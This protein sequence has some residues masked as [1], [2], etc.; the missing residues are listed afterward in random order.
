MAARWR[1]PSFLTCGENSDVGSGVSF[2]AEGSC[3]RLR[4]VEVVVV[5]HVDVDA[6]HVVALR[7]DEVVELGAVGVAQDAQVLAVAPLAV[8]DDTCSKT[9]NLN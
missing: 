3:H 8:V 4:V 6:T 9:N 2:G 7:L 1:H 5:V